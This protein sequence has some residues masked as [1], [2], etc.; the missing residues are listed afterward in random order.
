M[1]HY[2]KKDDTLDQKRE[3]ES[4]LLETRTTCMH[5]GAGDSNSTM[6][7]I[8]VKVKL[9]NSDKFKEMYA[10]LD[11]GSDATF[12]TTELMNELNVQGRK[13]KIQFR[14]PPPGSDKSLE[15]IGDPQCIAAEECT[16]DI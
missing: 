15:P 12:C 14:M 4:E 1:L 11:E 5:T 9:V 8:L 3:E 2:N 13:T 7:I 10:F 6:A 16:V